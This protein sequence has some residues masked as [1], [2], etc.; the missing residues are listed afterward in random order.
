MLYHIAK[1][2][3][4][5]ERKFRNA[6]SMVYHRSGKRNRKRC[7]K[8]GSK[9]GGICCCYNKKKNDFV[10]PQEYSKNVLALALDVS[11]P[12]EAIYNTAVHTAVKKF[13]RIDVL[14]NSVGFGAITNF[15]E[16][17]EESIRRLFEVNVFGLM[18]VTRAVLPIMRK[19]RS[20]HIFNIAS[21][22]G[23]CAGPVPYHT[24][25]FA[26]TGFSASLA[27]EAAPFGIKVTN[28]AP[29]LFRT[30]FYD[31]GKWGTVPD[32]H[33]ADYDTCRWQTE[34]IKNAERHEQAG[35]PTKLAELLLE[36]EA[37]PNPPLHLAVGADA[38][39]VI[40]N[41]C[42]KLKADTDAWREKAVNTSFDKQ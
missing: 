14:V 12:N 7:G 11:D 1:Y 39:E 15:E 36:V 20:G 13:G 26:V 9:D 17:S 37:S 18:R 6:K 33:I 38:P 24:S 28:V 8:C 16:T 5:Q 42:I 30:G 4:F 23:Y 22:A 41:L 29:G 31:K 10:I 19:Q 3:I 2:K 35:N 40:D 21:G 27:F 32:I 25:K 34:F